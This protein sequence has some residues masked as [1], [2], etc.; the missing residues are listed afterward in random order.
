MRTSHNR[1]HGLSQTTEYQIHHQ[2]MGRCYNP[3][4]PRYADYGAR[5]IRVCPEWHDVAAYIDAIRAMPKL[6]GDSLDRIDNDGNYEPSNVRFAS[7][8]KQRRNCRRIIPFTWNGETRVLK[9][10]A[11]SQG[12]PYLTVF[13]RIFRSHWPIAS[14]LGFEPPPAGSGRWPK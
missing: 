1:S 11:T 2:M 7:T 13:S 3:K 5:G 8:A 12:I 9:D 6:P 10:W 4:H 14:A